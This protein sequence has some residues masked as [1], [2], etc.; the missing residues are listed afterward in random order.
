MADQQ[1]V[2][3]WETTEREKL[4]EELIK[5]EQATIS[6]LILDTRN[7]ENQI[8][9]TELMWVARIHKLERYIDGSIK[10]RRDLIRR[11]PELASS[12]SLAELLAAL[13]EKIDRLVAV[14]RK[15]PFP[16]PE[17]Y[18]ADREPENR[19]LKARVEREIGQLQREFSLNLHADVGMNRGTSINTG[20]GP[21]IVNFGEIHGD[22]QQ[23]V[24]SLISSGHTELAGLLDRLAA[25]IE[26]LTDLGEER[27]AYLEQVRFIGQQAVA[28]TEK[29]QANVVRAVFESLRA[30]LQDTANLAQVL[31][32][33]GP[34]IARHF[35]IQWP[36]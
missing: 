19:R 27:A 11:F 1:E 7:P 12:E 18:P 28:P 3:Q 8:R 32:L 36:F 17:Q 10:I 15:G 33:A 2:I 30:R 16:A 23:V 14:V 22:V 34:A 20:G 13:S 24:G 9:R 4:F 5:E 35:G 25:G 26:A 31:T 21:A 6:G 29:R